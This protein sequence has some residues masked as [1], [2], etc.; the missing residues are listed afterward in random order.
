MFNVN[1]KLTDDCGLKDARN[2]RIALEWSV[3]EAIGYVG[4]KSRKEIQEFIETGGSGWPPALERT[5]E[6]WVRKKKPLLNLKKLVFYR[7]GKSHGQHR[8]IIKPG[9]YGKKAKTWQ[10]KM[11]KMEKISPLMLF[12]KAESGKTYRA[13][14]RLKKFM[15]GIG[16]PMRKQ[17]KTLQVPRRRVFQPAWIRTRRRMWPWFQ[18]KLMEKMIV[19]QMEMGSTRRTAKQFR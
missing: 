14:K 15:G 19:K 12:K 2:M 7:V 5:G 8:V 4:A 18:R 11:F 10:G 16:L 9:V 17:T 13:T 6:R 3:K 1:F